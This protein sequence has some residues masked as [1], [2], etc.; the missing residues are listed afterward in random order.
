MVNPDVGSRWVALNHNT[1]GACA[2]TGHETEDAERTDHGTIVADSPIRYPLKMK[3]LL[4]VVA[5]FFTSPVGTAEASPESSEIQEPKK[6]KKK[7]RANPKKAAKELEL[8]QRCATQYWEGV[9]WAD[10][11]RSASFIEDSNDR[12]EFQQWLEGHI[13]GR[14]IM[15]ATVMRVDVE[16]LEDKTSEVT[17][18][19][20]LS[21]ALKGYEMPEQI[22]KKEVVE[23]EWYL[24]TN[25]WWL[26]WESPTLKAR[27][28]AKAAQ[29]IEGT[30]AGSAETSP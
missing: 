13:E 9:R 19:A 30:E 12:M 14:K 15:E 10:T 28:A 16:P 17:S 23:Q 21:V 5:V 25:G 11:E 7:R 24:N 26:K 8:L 3:F 4:L 18:Q 1:M 20:F 6:K 22:L 2:E 27:E 29:A